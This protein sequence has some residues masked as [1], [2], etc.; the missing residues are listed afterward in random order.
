MVPVKLYFFHSIYSQY[1]TLKQNS[2]VFKRSSESSDN[3]VTRLL[4]GRGEYLLFSFSSIRVFNFFKKTRISFTWQIYFHFS[5]SLISISSAILAHFPLCWFLQPLIVARYISQEVATIL[6]ISRMVGPLSTGALIEE[7][8]RAVE[9]SIEAE[10]ERGSTR[11]T[12]R[13]YKEVI[14]SKNV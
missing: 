6:C 14:E 1:N 5:F 3:N 8:L 11:K 12:L 7:N 2:K 13:Y 9:I 10:K 4:A